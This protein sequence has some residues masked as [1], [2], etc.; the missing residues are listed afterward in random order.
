MD[1]FFGRNKEK[2]LL[3]ELYESDRAEFL[4][5]YGRRRVGK[6]YLINEYF[7]DKGIYF[8]LTGSKKAPRSEQLRNF[9]R[10]FLALFPEQERFTQ[11]PKDWG[12]A[13]NFLKEAIAK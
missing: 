7:K 1:F 2:K 10:E 11:P 3:K 5:I 13:L 4:A 8:E 12:E 6:T 9:Y